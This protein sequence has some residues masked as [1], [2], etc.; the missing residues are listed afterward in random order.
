MKRTT[1]GRTHRLEEFNLYGQ[2]RELEML[3]LLIDSGESLEDLLKKLAQLLTA[4]ELCG[5]RTH[6]IDVARWYEAACCEDVRPLTI[7]ESPWE[8]AG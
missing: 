3:R 4:A 1:E 8:Y 2:T 6:V 5:T 7:A